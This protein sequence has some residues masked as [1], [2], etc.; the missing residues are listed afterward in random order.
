MYVCVRTPVHASCMYSCVLCLCL[1]LY[2]YVQQK[3]VCIYI[4]TYRC[5]CMYVRVRV[6]IRVSKCRRVCVGV[7]LYVCMYVYIYVLYV[8]SGR[9]PCENLKS[10][11]TCNMGCGR[12]GSCFQ[13]CLARPPAWARPPPSDR[14]ARKDRL[15]PL[16]LSRQSTVA[17][18]NM[19]RS[20]TCRCSA[21][22]TVSSRLVRM[23]LC[24][25]LSS[26]WQRN[27]RR[28][29]VAKAKTFVIT[30]NPECANLE[31]VRRSGRWMCV[32]GGC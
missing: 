10:I 20:G 22:N 5:E 13:P 8:S 11:S 32:P 18:C 2:V 6:S 15:R 29:P 1:W 26:T 12:E 9:T 27:S 4:Y 3:C 24:Q 19:D 16:V 25:H 28:S 17:R 31:V 23:S 14:T 21:S 30:G 7:Y